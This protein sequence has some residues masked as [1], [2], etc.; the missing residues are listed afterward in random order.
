MY[1]KLLFDLSRE[2][3]RGH[4]LPTCDVPEK[5]L[6]D[7]IDSKYLRNKDADLPE[8]AENEVV[9]HFTALSVYESSCG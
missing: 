4:V 9:R 8:V 1:R 7:L 5:S 2:G 3:R 6:S